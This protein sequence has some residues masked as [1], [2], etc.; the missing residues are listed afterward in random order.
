MP[1]LS[2]PA[3]SPAVPVITSGSTN[4]SSPWMSTTISSS[5]PAMRY[6]SSTRAVPLGQSGDVITASAPKRR[7]SPA[8]RVSSVA[9]MTLGNAL[10]ARRHT[11]S[12]M[13]R[14]PIMARGLPGNLDEPQRAGIMPTASIFFPRHISGRFHIS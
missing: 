13:V 9:I 6:A 3:S 4:G 5:C 11:R 8:M 14:S 2:C 1:M 7:A 10:M 12:I